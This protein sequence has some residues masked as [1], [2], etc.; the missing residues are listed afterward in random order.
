MSPL[1]PHFTQFQ[2][3][4][5]RQSP[6]HSSWGEPGQVEGHGRFNHTDSAFGRTR[7]NVRTSSQGGAYYHG[8]GH[9]SAFRSISP[10]PSS[11]GGSLDGS[12]ANTRMQDSNGLTASIASHLQQGG[13]EGLVGQSKTSLA[14]EKR[15]PSGRTQFV[16]GFRLDC[17]RC[18]RREKGHFAHFS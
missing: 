12:E 13:V 10:A 15:T 17:E 1:A 8:Q 14:Q 5:Y 7:M 3:S 11:P 6:S 16:M 2:H 18:Q 9:I 4:G